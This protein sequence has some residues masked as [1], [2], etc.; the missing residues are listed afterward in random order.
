MVG[1][2]KWNCGCRFE[3]E[4][5][6]VTHECGANVSG[7]WRVPASVF[8]GVPLEGSAAS[9]FEMYRDIGLAETWWCVFAKIRFPVGGVETPA[10]R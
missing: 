4:N 10:K 3:R 6:C 7:K 9:F 8:C 1:D 2:V 5:G